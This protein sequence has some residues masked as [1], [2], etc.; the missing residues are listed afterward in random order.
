VFTRCFAAADATPPLHGE[1][2]VLSADVCRDGQQPQQQQ[3]QQQQSREFWTTVAT[4]D[5]ARI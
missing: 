1:T 2:I 5:R 4:D 3:Q